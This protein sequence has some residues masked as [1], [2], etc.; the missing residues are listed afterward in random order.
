MRV[1]ILSLFFC[2]TACAEGIQLK[3]IRK[4]E[5]GTIT[6]WGSCVYI[7]KFKLVTCFHTL[8]GAEEIY[9][10][11]KDG[12]AGVT[13]LK[14]DKENDLAL[15]ETKVKG[16]AVDLLPLPELTISAAHEDKPIRTTKATLNCA[17]IRA[18]VSEGSSGGPLLADGRIA[19]LILAKITL[20]GVIY[21]R[22][23]S[24]ATIAEFLK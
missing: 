14:F 18:D 16:D 11:V 3:A 6:A 21:A 24:S 22:I 10:K 15:I 8:D 13:I 2:L 17:I 23:V 4:S 9:I 5:K 20:E 12:W 1:L 7:E 19:G